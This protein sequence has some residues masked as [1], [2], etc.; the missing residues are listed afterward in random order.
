M[1]SRLDSINDWDD[2]AKRA[3]YRVALLAKH[4]KIHE[5]Q[6]RRYFIAKFRCSPRAW[7]IERKFESVRSHL[8][9]GDLVKEVAASAGFSRSSNFSRQF[10]QVYQVSPSLMRNSGSDYG[11]VRI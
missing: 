10:K 4:C 8:S 7:M 9:R 3:K 6:L 5:R 11:E 1:N 2:R